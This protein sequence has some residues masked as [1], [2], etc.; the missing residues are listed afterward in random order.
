MAMVQLISQSKELGTLSGFV[1]LDQTLAQ[2]ATNEVI[3][4]T[5]GSYRLNCSSKK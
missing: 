4:A 5:V 1:Y 3:Y 2:L